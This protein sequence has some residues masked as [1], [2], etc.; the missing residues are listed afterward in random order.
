MITKNALAHALGGIERDPAG[1]H[2]VQAVKAPMAALDRLVRD[3]HEAAVQLR[4]V[5][6]GEVFMRFP[7][8][9]RDL[10]RS[11]DRD[12]ALRL[13]GETLEADRDVLESLFEPLVHLV[14]NS[15]DHGI[16]S[17]EARRAAGKPATAALILRARA[18]AEA[19]VIEVEDDGR[20][21]DNAALRSRAVSRGLLAEA[22][23]AGLSEDE[24]S[25]LIFLPG[26]ST[27]SGVSALSGRGGRHGC[28]AQRGRACG[29]G[30]S[31]CRTGVARG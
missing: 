25:E 14:R 7:R 19:L 1:A 18:E 8:L 22:E 23:A 5:P 11:L 29:G 30:A 9:V 17:R 12:V 3:W 27:A 21:L 16:E 20:G 6:V 10:A 4:M 31:P 15:L 26:L 24:S 13:S 28:G 2:L